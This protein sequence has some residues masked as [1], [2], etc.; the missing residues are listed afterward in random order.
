MII[1]EHRVGP[2]TPL[3]FDNDLTML[4]ILKPQTVVCQDK[5][6]K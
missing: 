6:Q 3:T 4:P 5:S 2:L 1:K